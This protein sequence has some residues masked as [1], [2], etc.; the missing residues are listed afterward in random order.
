[1][2]YIL[3]VIIFFAALETLVEIANVRS[4]MLS[5]FNGVQKELEIDKEI[6]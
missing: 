5:A 2:G 1:M 6:R 4:K 3:K